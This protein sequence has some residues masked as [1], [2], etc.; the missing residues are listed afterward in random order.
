[1]ARIAQL[2]RQ[3]V[4]YID[5]YFS[6]VASAE[7]L[8]AWACAHPVFANP[9]ALDNHDDWIVSSALALMKLLADEKANRAG[10]EKGL[11]EARQFLTGEK[12]FPDDRWPTSL[13][14]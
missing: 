7:E 6:G 13:L 11:H 1:M 4:A 3:A 12:L 2:K 5:R 10:T 9:K 14:K 8:R